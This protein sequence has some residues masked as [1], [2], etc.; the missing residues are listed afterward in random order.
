RLHLGR[1]RRQRPDPLPQLGDLPQ[2]RPRP[3]ALGQARGRAPP[4]RSARDRQGGAPPGR[5]RPRPRRPVP[6]QEEKGGL[7]LRNLVRSAPVT[8]RG[9]LWK[10]LLIGGAL[11]AALVYTRLVIYPTSVV[12]LTDALPLLYCIWCRDR[13]LLWG[14]TAVLL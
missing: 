11:L 14:M 8:P 5:G 2:P 1:R 3:A 9:P 7:G 4:R 6:L 10:R 13:R 12:P